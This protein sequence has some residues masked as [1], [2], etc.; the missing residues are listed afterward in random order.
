MEQRLVLLNAVDEII[1][2]FQ[3]AVR[4]NSRVAQNNDTQSCLHF[5]LGLPAVCV[6]SND[7]SLEWK[8]TLGDV[9]TK[10]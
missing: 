3:L 4:N 2:L 10:K 1:A 8:K 7:Y 5:E 9:K 6:L